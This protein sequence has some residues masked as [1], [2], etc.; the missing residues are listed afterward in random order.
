MGAGT[1]IQGMG[2]NEEREAAAQNVVGVGGGA[3]PLVPLVAKR[4]GAKAIVPEYAPV[5]NAIGA[6]VARPTITL[7]LRIDTERGEYT[8]SEEGLTGKVA[9]RNMNIDQAEE[10]ARKLLTER[11]ERLGISEYAK[12][13]EVTYSEIFNM[14]RGWSTVGRLLD[15]RMEIPAGILEEWRR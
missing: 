10:M 11:A 6:A 4:L 7:N 2:D 14:V 9:G 15:V 12:E 13:A 5:A 1:C 8:V 3:P